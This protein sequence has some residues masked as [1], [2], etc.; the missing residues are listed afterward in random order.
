MN[1]KNRVKYRLKRLYYAPATV[2]EETGD[3]AYATPI[4]MPDAVSISLSPKGDLIVTYADAQEIILGRD[5]AGYDGEA[6]LLRIQESFETDCLGSTKN[7]DGTIDE[8]EG[9]NSKPF[10]LLFEFEGD[11]K[12]I[13]HCMFLCY[14]SKQ[15]L[16]GSNSESK[17]PTND[18]IAIKCRARADG[19]IKTKTGDDTTEDVYNNWYN[20]VPGTNAAEAAATAAA[21]NQSVDDTNTDENTD[22]TDAEE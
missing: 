18:K 22:T 5:N 12:G 7:A 2:D 14:A 3:V 17:A 8:S 13:R 20:A 4:R 19:K 6:E 11:K 15:T 1:Q 10:A 21:V 9:D 16:D